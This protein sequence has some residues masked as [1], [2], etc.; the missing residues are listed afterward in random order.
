MTT[1]NNIPKVNY[2]VSNKTGVDVKNQVVIKTNS[3]KSKMIYFQ[4]YDSTICA[5][6]FSNDTIYIG[7][8]WDYSI[9]TMKYF[10]QFLSSYLC[11]ED[12]NKKKIEKGIEIGFIENYK[13]VY[14]EDLY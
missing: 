4:S 11:L 6:D 1:T 8:R 10:Y 13:C 2:L 7:E 14:K 5:V 9:T 12:M 3:A